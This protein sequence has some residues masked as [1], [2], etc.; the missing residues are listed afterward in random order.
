MLLT[1]ILPFFAA[2][3]SRVLEE[4]MNKTRLSNTMFRH[5]KLLKYNLRFMQIKFFRPQNMTFTQM[6]LFTEHNRKQST[7]LRSMEFDRQT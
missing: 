2:K 1:C 5:R 6:N 4:K 3:G 7:G